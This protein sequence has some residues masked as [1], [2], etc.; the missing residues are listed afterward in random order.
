MF[1]VISMAQHESH[2]STKVL[3]Y[4]S[5]PKE[6]HVTTGTCTSYDTQTQEIGMISM[7]VH[8]FDIPDNIPCPQ[9]GLDESF[10]VSF[11]VTMMSK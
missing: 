9:P 1:L 4:M 8:M 7:V 11:S 6:P 3:R 5:L 2:Q 10:I